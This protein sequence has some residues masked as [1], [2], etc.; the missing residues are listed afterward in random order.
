MEGKMKKI[1]GLGLVAL[2]I[3]LFGLLQP[4]RAQAEETTTI[5]LHRIVFPEEEASDV[6]ANQG[7]RPL[8]DAKFGV[9]DVSER[10]YEIVDTGKSYQEAQKQISEEADQAVES[11]KISQLYTKAAE[12]QLTKEDGK[13]SFVLSTYH[14]GTVGKV[15]LFIEKSVPAGVAYRASNLVVG[16]PQENAAGEEV[17]LYLKNHLI[18]RKP[19]FYKYG[20]D[21]TG[22]DEGALAGAEF[23][24]YKLVKDKKYYLHEAPF[25]NGNKWVASGEAEIKT[26]I[27]DKLGKVSLGDQA[28]TPGT[29]YFEEIKAPEGFE[30]T[31]QAKKIQVLIP[32]NTEEAIQ[33]MI[34]NK[35]FTM[36]QAKVRNTRPEKPT[37][38]TEP[39]EPSE[40]T[41]PTEPTIPS[42]EPVPTSPDPPS[43][44]GNRLPSTLGASSTTSTKRLPQTGMLNQPIMILAGAVVLLLIG[45]VIYKRNQPEE[46]K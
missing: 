9:Y 31:E 39:T 21:A 17:H 18:V 25:N 30:I 10:F 36:D 41:E 29:Y 20:Q 8:K 45:F 14:S 5:T 19:Y 23:Q 13:A 32:A 12:D 15:Y 7:G 38:P 6:A 16:L 44:N 4:Q 26:F 3:S 33:I 43:G 2:V 46:E 35:T 34:D 11:G 42:E 22:K 37:T 28:L 27:S 24:L 40:P 1:R